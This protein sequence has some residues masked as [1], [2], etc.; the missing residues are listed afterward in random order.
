M[1]L[2]A[3]AAATILI[4]GCDNNSPDDKPVTN[5]PDHGKITLTTD[6]SERGEG[7]DV[8]S[9][10]HVRRNGDDATRRTFTEQA[11]VMHPDLFE[12]GTHRLH[13]WHDAEGISVSGNTASVAAAAT[14]AGEI[15]EMPGWF[16]S[17]ATDVVVERDKVHALTVK[18]HQQVR[19]LTLTIAPEGEVEGIAATLGGVAGTLNIDTHEH[20]SPS[21]IAPTFTKTADD[22]WSATVRVLGIAGSE[23]KLSGTITLK[24]GA[25]K[26]FETD[27]SEE[28]KNFNDN[29]KAPIE[30]A[31]DTEG[32]TTPP[33]SPTLT[34]DAGK[35]FAIPASTVGTPIG[36]L[37]M[38]GAAKGGTI[39]YIYSASGLP[40]GI[41]IDSATGVIS[42]TPTTAGSAGTATITVTDSSTPAQSVTISVSFGAVAA[43][44]GDGGGGT[45]PPPPPVLV[46][47]VTLDQSTLDLKEGE[48]ATLTATVAPANASNKSVTW[49]SDDETIATVDNAGKVTA[50]KAG[51]ATIT[52]KTTEGGKTE[53]CAV[54]VTSAPGFGGDIED[55]APGQGGNGNAEKAYAVGDAYPNAENPI[56]IVFHVNATGLHGK[57]VHPQEGGG[58]KQAASDWCSSLAPAGTWRMPNY[59]YYSHGGGEIY[60]LYNAWNADRGAFS[61]SLRALGGVELKEEKYWMFGSDQALN[62]VTFDFYSGS[63]ASTDANA[64]FHVRAIMA[65]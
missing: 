16:F 25:E 54:S 34:V 43:S 31:V 17:D 52:V 60:D 47:G 19:E 14:R 22:K 26:A 7:V 13:I 21:N 42:G 20:G 35:S 53:T 37:N 45:P 33:P 30:L 11:D 50:I 58:T 27:L 12:P 1:T 48:E 65:F 44:G 38:A 49:E 57:V 3:A 32:G 8:P 39:P 61:A 28:L 40:A 10:F 55:W 23:Q 5:H 51:N 9:A 29:K 36:S 41:A 15:S 4:S 6:W 2:I 63:A 18:M 24:D 56:G 46:T 64:Q 59:D 62:S